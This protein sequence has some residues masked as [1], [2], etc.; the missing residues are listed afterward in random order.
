VTIT[1]F[2]VSM[3][4]RTPV[5]LS[6]SLSWTRAAAVAILMACASGLGVPQAEAAP[7]TG[8]RWAAAGPVVGY[9]TFPATLELNSEF[10]IGARVSLGLSDRVAVM[11][12]G[13]H[14]DPTRKTSQKVSSFG[15]IRALFSYNLRRTGL[16]PYLVT[17]LGGMILNF[18][19]APASASAVVAA[20]GGVQFD[21]GPEWLVMFEGTADMYKGRY[22][23]YSP[24]GQELSSTERQMHSIG[25]FSAGLQYR[26]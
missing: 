2:E 3:T 13:A 22:V 23:T 9:R 18:H 5:R 10:A 8:E 6:T 15:D 7:P 26:F 21:L 24:T 4:V 20:G 12:D 16:R 11:I 17:G 1:P 25:L 14:A 19:D